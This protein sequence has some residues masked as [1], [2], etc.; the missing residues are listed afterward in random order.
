MRYFIFLFHV[1]F[2]TLLGLF[3]Y[4]PKV[5]NDY[6]RICKERERDDQ[7]FGDFGSRMMH[8]MGWAKGEGEACFDIQPGCW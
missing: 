8:K 7:G 2:L 3:K 6:E 4:D 5:P 1:G